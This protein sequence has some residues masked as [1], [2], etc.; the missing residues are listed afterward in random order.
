MQEKIVGKSKEERKA[1]KAGE[2]TGEKRRADNPWNT[3]RSS[4]WERK[5][6]R[7]EGLQCEVESTHR[8]PK[9]E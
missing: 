9:R 7:E 4:G 8:I 5:Q 3:K 2:Q 6:G 1:R